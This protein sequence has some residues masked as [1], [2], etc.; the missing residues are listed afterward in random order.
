MTSIQAIKTKPQ[1]QVYQPKHVGYMWY[2]SGRP[3]LYTIVLQHHKVQT[4]GN[5][6]R[7]CHSI[8][9]FATLQPAP[10]TAAATQLRHAPRLQLQLDIPPLPLLS[11]LECTCST[12]GICICVLVAG[13][14]C[15]V[16]GDLH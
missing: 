12:E 10:Y 11:L 2:C 13:V 6:F 14:T 5:K 7:L 1:S 4:T 8:P 3:Q 9:P 15:V 16:A